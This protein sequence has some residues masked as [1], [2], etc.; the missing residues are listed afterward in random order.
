[1]FVDP[2]LILFDRIV[3]AEHTTYGDCKDK[4]TWTPPV[5]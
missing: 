1:V 3:V 5:G 2:V 4:S